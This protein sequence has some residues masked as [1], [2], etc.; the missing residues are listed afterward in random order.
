MKK[1]ATICSVFVVFV[2]VVAVNFCIQPF[3]FNAPELPESL[4]KQINE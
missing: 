4:K 3:W 1:F 2:A